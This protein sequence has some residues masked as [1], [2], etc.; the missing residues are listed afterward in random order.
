MNTRKQ[1]YK[2]L[3]ANSVHT[4]SETFYKGERVVRVRP[5]NEYKVAQSTWYYDGNL[6]KR[7]ADVESYIDVI[8]AEK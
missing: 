7:W 8:K 4:K 6:F 2:I 3:S 5:H 1:E